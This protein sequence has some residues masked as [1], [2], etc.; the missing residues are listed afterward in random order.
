[1]YQ[2]ANGMSKKETH[3]CKI[4]RYGDFCAEQH[5]GREIS[6]KA[7]KSSKLAHWRPSFGIQRKDDN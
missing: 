6:W 3:S 2:L 5:K 4:G 7:E 1:M